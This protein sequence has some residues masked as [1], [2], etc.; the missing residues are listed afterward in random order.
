MN[1]PVLMLIAIPVLIEYWKFWLRGIGT[2]RRQRINSFAVMEDL[3][4]VRKIRISFYASSIHQVIGT[5][6]SIVSMFEP[7]KN[8]IRYR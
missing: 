3:E 4:G 5:A 7:M 1:P 8:A 2:T 6:D